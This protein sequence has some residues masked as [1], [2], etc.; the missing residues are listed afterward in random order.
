MKQDSKKKKMFM[1]RKKKVDEPT[2][3]RRHIMKHRFASKFE[4][5]VYLRNDMFLVSSGTCDSAT[6]SSPL[7]SFFCCCSREL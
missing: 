4:E 7:H 5:K 3:D 1:L 6:S 2:K